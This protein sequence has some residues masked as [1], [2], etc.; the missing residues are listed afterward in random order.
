M[1]I[2]SE[3]LFVW[4]EP[5]T[6]THYRLLKEQGVEQIINLRS[7]FMESTDHDLFEASLNAAF[8]GFAFVVACVFPILPPSLYVCEKIHSA[9][10]TRKGLTLVHCKDSVDRT[11]VVLLHFLLK[12]GTAFEDAWRMICERGMHRR[13]FW[14]KWIL[15]RRYRLKNLKE[16]H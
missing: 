9:V 3:K 14:W 11:G 15:K 7:A 13:F 10:M 16:K 6:L 4:R 5:K 12:D 2:F 1:P 8:H